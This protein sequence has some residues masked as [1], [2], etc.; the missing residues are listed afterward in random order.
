MQE[1]EARPSGQHHKRASQLEHTV[2]G[3]RLEVCPYCV[4]EHSTNA[5]VVA[6]TSK[7]RN[8]SRVCFGVLPLLGSVGKF[9]LQQ[10]VQTCVA[11]AQRVQRRMPTVEALLRALRA[12]HAGLSLRY[13]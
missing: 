11:C 4:V 7:S 13:K 12:R 2:C 6:F 9:N 5:S 1:H 10:K 3:E 8:R